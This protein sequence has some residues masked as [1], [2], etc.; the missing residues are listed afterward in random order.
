[1]RISWLY[2]KW[3]WR[4]SQQITQTEKYPLAFVCEALGLNDVDEGNWF[5][6]KLNYTHFQMEISLHRAPAR[7]LTQRW[8]ITS[9]FRLGWRLV[10]D[11]VQRKWKHERE[12]ILKVPFHSR[13]YLLK[14]FSCAATIVRYFWHQFSC[15]VSYFPPY[16]ID[17]KH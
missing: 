9:D 4:A 1:M 6:V 12:I 7:C 16:K 10:C 8:V 3:N 13:S 2:R 11:K 15:R 14:L 17:R 5:S